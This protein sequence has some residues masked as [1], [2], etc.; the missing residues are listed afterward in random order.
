MIEEEEWVP[1]SMIDVPKNKYFVS[2]NGKIKGPRG[3]FRK[4]INAVV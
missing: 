1:I 3:I 4:K 2:P